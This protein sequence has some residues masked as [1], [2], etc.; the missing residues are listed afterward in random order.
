MKKVKFI[1]ALL[2]ASILVTGVIGC[3]SQ[4]KKTANKAN[5]ISDKSDESKAEKK[6][7]DNQNVDGLVKN[8]LSSYFT[9]DKNDYEFY[10][11]VSGDKKTE[12]VS[13][14]QMASFNNAEKFKPYFTEKSYRQFILNR[15][16]L[17]RIE[18]AYKGKYYVEVKNISFKEPEIYKAPERMVYDCSIDI[19]KKS[20]IGEADKFVTINQK[21]DVY[22]EK[23]G[24]RA[25]PFRPSNT[26]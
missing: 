7:E 4:E 25:M 11:Q 16:Q 12:D 15:I 8:Y 24:W 3:S 10:D 22:K 20:L 23:E 14:V 6:D 17:N 18:A 21:I 9:V 13:K 26:Q 2:L 1:S 19:V 5:K